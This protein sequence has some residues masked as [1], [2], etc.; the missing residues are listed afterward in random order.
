LTKKYCALN[1][2][3]QH[4]NDEYKIQINNLTKQQNLLDENLNK[5][6]LERDNLKN[7]LENTNQQVSIIIFFS[8]SSFYLCF[9]SYMI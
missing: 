3:L 5:C 8:L 6:E 7:S 1:D 2:K 4:E 9:L